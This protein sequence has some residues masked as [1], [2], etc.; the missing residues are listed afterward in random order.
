[1]KTVLY[2]GESYLGYEKKVIKLIETVLGYNCIYID[3]NKYQYKYKN[4]FERIYA[5][6]FYRFF[7]K[8]IYKKEKI[9]KQIIKDID[10]IDNK[11]DIIFF[12]RPTSRILSLLEY[13]K[14]KNIKMISHQWDSL[15]K[16]KDN[17][18]YTK[19]FDKNIFFDEKDALKFKGKFLPN[20]YSEINDKNELVEY[21]IYSIISHGK[22]GNRIIELEKIAKNLFENGLKYL[23]LVYTKE[24]NIKSKYLTIINT[25]ISLEENYQNMKKSK[26]ILEIGD[27]ENQGGLT[28][29]AIDSLG[30]KKKLITNY[31]FI[32]NYDFYNEN[33]IFVLKE[34]CYNIPK[35]FLESE[36]KEL[37]DKIYKKY[38]GETW[39]RNIFENN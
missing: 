5:N 24:K 16:V 34:N 37:D 2:I 7:Y 25:P 38:S 23:F 13:L 32:T 39:I 10:K 33:N 35:E 15:K 12:I 1:M 14:S 29:R 17:G 27:L 4:I 19:F 18:E 30:L 31:G 36:Y 9:T 8:R 20:F 21:E 26:I 28:F 22:N 3:L 6:S 11:I